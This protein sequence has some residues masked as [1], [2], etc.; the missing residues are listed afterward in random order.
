MS[1][2]GS[3]TLTT[4]DSRQRYKTPDKIPFPCQESFK[5]LFDTR[6]IKTNRFMLDQLYYASLPTQQTMFLNG[7]GFVLFCYKRHI[8]FNFVPLLSTCK[9][10]S[11]DVGH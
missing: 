4:L 11:I 2:M 7:S 5:I 6:A 9:Q 8:I 3:S 10:Q 1:N